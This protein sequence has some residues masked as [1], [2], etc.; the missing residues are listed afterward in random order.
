[1]FACS[2]K[3]AQKTAILKYMDLTMKAKFISNA[4]DNGRAYMELYFEDGETGYAIGD[5]IAIGRM[6][7]NGEEYICR[8]GGG[9]WTAKPESLQLA[10]EPQ[11]TG[12][13]ARILLKPVYV[14]GVLI[15][16]DYSIKLVRKDGMIKNGAIFNIAGK[17]EPEKKAVKAPDLEQAENAAKSTQRK[18]V[19]ELQQDMRR[20][21]AAAEILLA[22]PEVEQEK[23][24]QQEGTEKKEKSKGLYIAGIIIVL[25]IVICWLLMM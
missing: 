12:N 24:E 6:G 18:A 13:C 2:I 3:K 22:E 10:E 17:P 4:A 19:S 15:G 16:G 11:I 5:T 21:E 20:E 1:M 14:D 7:K 23:E 25:V 9:K 8:T